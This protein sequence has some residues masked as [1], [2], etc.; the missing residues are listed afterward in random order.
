MGKQ[1]QQT[2]PGPYMERTGQHP[3]PIRGNPYSHRFA[4][5]WIFTC[6]GFV[7]GTTPGY[8]EIIHM[9]VKQVHNGLEQQGY[10]RGF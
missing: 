1:I 6:G 9:V 4:N 2:R 10:R 8:P 7:A 3:H 5:K